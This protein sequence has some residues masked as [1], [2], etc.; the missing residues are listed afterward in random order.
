MRNVFVR[1]VIKA[2][3]FVVFLNFFNKFKF[4]FFII[5]NKGPQGAICKSTVSQLT[6][7]V[8][9]ITMS[10]AYIRQSI[11]LTYKDKDSRHAA[12]RVGRVQKKSSFI[13]SP[14]YA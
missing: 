5:P 12:Q 2:F 10:S 8:D 14:E 4:K 3:S 9:N 11:Y 6:E 7:G 1:S 13:I